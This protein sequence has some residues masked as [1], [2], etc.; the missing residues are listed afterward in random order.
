MLIGVERYVAR[1]GLAICI[2]LL[3]AGALLL[4]ISGEESS[5]HTCSIARDTMLGAFLLALI[6]LLVY[7]W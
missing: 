6:S 2:V 7:V 5:A 1:M 3:N 4:S